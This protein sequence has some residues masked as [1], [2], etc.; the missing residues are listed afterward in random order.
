MTEKG[1]DMNDLKAGCMSLTYTDFGK[2][3]SLKIN[4]DEMLS[5][6]PAGFYITDVKTGKECVFGG[7]LLSEMGI[8]MKTE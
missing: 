4:G 2:A 8:E 6:S 5:D 3:E 1:T 7:D